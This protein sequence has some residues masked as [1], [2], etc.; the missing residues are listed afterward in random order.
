[1]SKSTRK[2]KVLRFT[3]VH[4]RN[5]KNFTGV[6]L[7][8]T[9]RVFVVGPNASGK[10]NFLDVF[11][12]LRDIASEGG[13]LQE[14]VRK[15]GGIKAVRSLSARRF[16]EVEIRVRVGSSGA[17]DPED[18]LW[19]YSLSFKSEKNRLVVK[20]EEVFKKDLASGRKEKLLERPDDYDRQDPERLSQTYME[21][22][23]MN[24]D[25]R[26]LARF[27]ASVR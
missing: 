17:T 16:P 1:M 4:L 6:E 2:A 22:I 27:F 7:Y 14:A 20:K 10:S 9:Q 3:W 23:T 8:L 21:Q 5:W 18:F 25:F 13:G 19:E 26:E 15:R 12:F 11:R 24:R